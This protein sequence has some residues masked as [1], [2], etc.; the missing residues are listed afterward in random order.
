MLNARDLLNLLG[1]GTGWTSDDEAVDELSHALQTTARAIDDGADDGLVVAAALHDIGRYPTVRA[2]FPGVAHEA[3]GAA[4]ATELFGERVGWLIGAHVAAK[5]YLVA[6]DLAY[7][8]QLS[9]ASVVSLTV[10]GGPFTPG[11]VAAFESGRW[12]QQAL[13]LRRW[14]D[15]AKIPGAPVPSLLDLLPIFERTLLARFDQDTRRPDQ[16][17]H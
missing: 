3:A 12:A 13:A 7:A 15:A 10:Q 11:D 2:R 14:D 16:R 17:C 4:F 1:T 8:R 5:R 9:R 6:T